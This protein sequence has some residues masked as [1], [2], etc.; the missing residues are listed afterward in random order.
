MAKAAATG[1]DLTGIRPLLDA[2][3]SGR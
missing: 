1:Y 2:L 3:A